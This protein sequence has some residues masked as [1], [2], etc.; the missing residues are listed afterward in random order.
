M[1]VLILLLFMMGC[2]SIPES[3]TYNREL[4]QDD[5]C[6]ESYGSKWGYCGKEADR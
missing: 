6:L 3:H 1:Y 5:A 4:K 2:E